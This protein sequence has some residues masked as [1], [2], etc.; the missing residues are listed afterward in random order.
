MWWCIA[1]ELKH[2][3]GLWDLHRSGESRTKRKGRL[4]PQR[5]STELN[6]ETMANMDLSCDANQPK[7]D[8]IIG[9]IV[10]LR[11][12]L[13]FTPSYTVILI[14]PIHVG[15]MIFVFFLDQPQSV[16]TQENL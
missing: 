2:V 8:Q 10:G 16:Y 11:L 15:T 7:F 4:E 1:S 14:H 12:K 5:L 13:L 3:K 6:L 9:H